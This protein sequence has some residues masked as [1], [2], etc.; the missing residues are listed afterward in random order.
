MTKRFT[1]GILG[2]F[3]FLAGAD[4]TA[5]TT[6]CFTDAAAPVVAYN[7]DFYA[8]DGL[9]LVNPRGLTKTS[10]VRGNPH[11]WNASFG[12]LT[13]NQFGRDLPM[14]GINE[15]GLFVSQMWLDEGKYPV[16]DVRPQVNPLEWVQVQLD[17][18]ASVADVLKTA[19][20]VRIGSGPSLH[21]L[22]ADRAGNVAVIEFL[23]G[24]LRARTGAELP[25]PA[26][27]NST[28][29][30][31]IAYLAR[32]KGFGGDG[33]LPIVP[34][35]GITSLARFVV[36]AVG[37]A[38]TTDGD[39]IARAFGTLDRARQSTSTQWSIV[40]ELGPLRAHFRTAGQA[41]IRRVDLTALDLACTQ[42]A[43]MLDIDASLEGDVTA[44]FTRYTTA[45]NLN[46]VMRSFRNTPFLANTPDEQIQ[47]LARQP[48]RA[49]CAAADAGGARR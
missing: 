18:A 44:R 14:T 43:R 11:T 2:L 36:A 42:P 32:H 20:E 12:S 9:V 10:V 48:E 31:S 40:Y 15:R 39:P 26:L 13:F 35:P 30:D 23:D 37:R 1:T 29:A 24:E 38:T 46:L 8:G 34:A 41:A 21:F 4:A 7:Y 3:V 22:A 25:I 16:D 47:S 5:C 6:V 17:T 27:T 49:R 28:Y 33:P 19:R 45:A